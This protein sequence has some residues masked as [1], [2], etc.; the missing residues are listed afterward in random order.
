MFQPYWA[1][2][3]LLLQHEVCASL[4]GTRT[5]PVFLKDA[6]ALL[7]KY[8]WALTGENSVGKYV[9]N[10]H[11]ARVPVTLLEPEMGLK[12]ERPLLFCPFFRPPLPKWCM[13]SSQENRAQVHLCPAQITLA[14]LNLGSHHVILMFGKMWHRP[15]CS[16]WIQDFKKKKKV[17]SRMILKVRF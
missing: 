11:R 2:V 16:I 12:N 17:Y 1:N 9:G 10:F 13:V 8:F 15:G 5:L 14:P 6:F 4:T 3:V 7:C